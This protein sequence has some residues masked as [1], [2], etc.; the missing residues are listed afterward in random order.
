MEFKTYEQK[1]V[2][3]LLSMTKVRHLWKLRVNG[4]HYEI[5]A[6]ESLISGKFVVMVQSDI[7]FNEKVDKEAKKKGLQVHGDGLDL[8]FRTASK[9]LDLFVNG[10]KFEPNKGADDDFYEG[11]SGR[12]TKGRAPEEF[13]TAKRQSEQLE[14]S[15]T[16][17]DAM[18]DSDDDSNPFDNFDSRPAQ[19]SQKPPSDAFAKG[20]FDAFGKAANEPFSKGSSDAFGGFGGPTPGGKV[21]I[22][23]K[24]GDQKSMG[25]KFK[26]AGGN[27][28]GFGGPAK[29]PFA[30]AR[31][32]DEDGWGSQPSA[33]TGDGGWTAV[34]GRD[35]EE[36]QAD[37]FMNFGQQQP[38]QRPNLL[39]NFPSKNPVSN[40]ARN[41]GFDAFNAPPARNSGFDAFGVQS[42]SNQ[43]GNKQFAQ[44]QQ[45]KPTDAFSAFGKPAQSSG[46]AFDA[47]GQQ[48]KPTTPQQ[49]NMWSNF[50][51]NKPV[52]QPS[53]QPF[54]QPAHQPQ[55]PPANPFGAQQAPRAPQPAVQ[56]MWS[57]FQ[58]NPQTKPQQ[59][60][61]QQKPQQQQFQ[62]PQQ[63]QPQQ[64]QFQQQPQQQQFQQ[65]QPQQFQQ[66]PQ[67]QQQQQQQQF[68]Q[69]FQQ[70]PQQQPQQP[71]QQ[72]Q[73]QPQQQ[74]QY[75]QQQPQQ[76]YQQQPQQ[77]P[78]QQYQQ[79]Q[80]QQQQQQ[81]QNAENPFDAGTANWND[82]FH[83]PVQT[84]AVSQSPDQH[85][86]TIEQ[87][88]F[89]HNDVMYPKPD[90]QFAADS[91]GQSPQQPD[92][93]SQA[94][95]HF[96]LGPPLSQAGQPSSDPFA[97]GP[98]QAQ[99]QAQ[100]LGDQFGQMSFGN[101]SGDPQAQQQ[102]SS[103]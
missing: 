67:P 98:D 69:Q 62:Q 80:F 56:N 82:G 47:F 6:A 83:Q 52:Q 75:Q 31:D 1:S 40:P 66:Q 50:P 88:P 76:Q 38:P 35:N 92:S 51:T 86:A 42:G 94:A 54:Q 33:K 103:D 65:P 84:E 73:Q 57:N 53:Q 63:S 28:P 9:G 11:S 25:L 36:D 32:D 5:K 20:N 24:P 97:V 43:S 70:Q 19:K 95:P 48:G 89:K 58:A 30:S 61:F 91:A 7:V 23:G 2:G 55:R 49:G 45:Q 90:L 71:Q 96:D 93:Q 85:Q 46:S 87:N 100:H 101:S 37:G 64:Q 22:S 41:N 60:Q 27:K 68:Q 12:V 29:D 14:S 16:K 18:D 10:V 74:P 13:G 99:A 34:G 3:K 8:T 15:W 77:Q 21:N 44:P 26:P 4:H 72:F 17:F 39:P 78:Q 102:P 59:Q 81:P 79:Q